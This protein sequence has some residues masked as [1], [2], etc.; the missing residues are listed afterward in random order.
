MSWEGC[1][2]PA[3]S[4]TPSPILV[5]ENSWWVASTLHTASYYVM[6]CD[7]MLWYFMI[8]YV[9][10]RYVISKFSLWASY[11]NALLRDLS[12]DP[13][14]SICLSCLLA[15]FLCFLLY[16]MLH[17]VLFLFYSNLCWYSSS[18]SNLIAVEDLA[19]CSVT[20]SRMDW[21]HLHKTNTSW[22]QSHWSWIHLHAI[23]NV[24]AY[25]R[26]FS[27]TAL[28]VRHML[29][30]VFQHWVGCRGVYYGTR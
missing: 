18:Q 6:L 21:Q 3:S 11:G 24:T 20:Q 16:L 10:L 13:L 28:D 9:M 17:L 14:I 22:R 19:E 8:W 29:C 25:E 12:I 4:G 7:A 1:T 26:F 23:G 5:R 15:F 2:G 30:C 27:Y